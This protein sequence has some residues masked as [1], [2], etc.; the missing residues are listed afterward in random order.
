MG[1]NGI[2]GIGKMGKNLKLKDDC[3]TIRKPGLIS[4]VGFFEWEDSEYEKTE[5]EFEVDV[6]TIEEML[7]NP[8]KSEP[9]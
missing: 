5:A 3:N 2:G 7:I 4:L 9:K 8:Q 1:M 6:K